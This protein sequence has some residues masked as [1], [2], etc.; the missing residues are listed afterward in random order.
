MISFVKPSIIPGFKFSF[1]FGV[2][3]LFFLVIVPLFTLI[4][5]SFQIGFSGFLR[6][7][8]DKQVLS[9]L[10]FSLSTSFCAAIVNLIF[11]F[12]IAWSLARYEFFGKRI[13]D[14][15]VDLPFALP[16]A[17]AGIALSF[18]LAE[19]GILGAFLGIFGFE[20]QRASFFGVCL[21][22]VFIGMPFVVRTLEPVIKD[23]DDSS[24]E[25]A[26]CLGANFW[27]TFFFVVIPSLL[28]AALT[29]FALAFAR[30]LGE[31]GSVIF[32]SSNIPF[33]SQ[34]LP[35]V[36]VSKIESHDYL[37]ASVVGVFMIVVSF[38]L[39]FAIA[40]LQGKRN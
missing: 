39:L 28:P 40:Y 34:I 25:A 30:G 7:I 38:L 35:V 16:T 12:V 15:L 8:L 29:G 11:G 3:Y 9:A 10:F 18:L 13:L 19:S 20:A 14:A 24:L 1:C 21:A 36:I 27:Q 6:A 5:F 23:F 4:A 17:V 33:E 26:M 37:G 2:G 31:Y 22:L 32:I